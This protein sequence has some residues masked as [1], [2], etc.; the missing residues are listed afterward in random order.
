MLP[1]PDQ[2]HRSFVIGK[3]VPPSLIPL[4][5]CQPYLRITRTIYPVAMSVFEKVLKADLED[6]NQ[7]LDR[8]RSPGTRKDADVRFLGVT[9][10]FHHCS[11]L[12]A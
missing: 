11:R 7:L 8:R 2:H 1:R 9:G 10:S 5:G 4:S 12:F 3:R 6:V